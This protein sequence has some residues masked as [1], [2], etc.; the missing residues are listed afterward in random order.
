MVPTALREPLT[1]QH[2]ADLHHLAHAKV[3]TSLARHYFWPSMRADIRRWLADCTECENEKG[4]RRLA[5]GLF[6]DHATTEPRSRYSMDFQG[7][8]QAITGETE[9]LAV[10][11]AFTKT[12]F[13]LPLKDRTAPTFVPIL[14]D[15]IWFTRGAPDSIHTDAAPEL[16]SALL[17][18]VSKPRHTTA[19]GHNAQSNGEIESWWRFWKRCM[20]LQFCPCLNTFNGRLSRNAFALRTTLSPTKLSEAPDNKTVLKDTRPS[21]HHAP[22]TGDISTED[23]PDL[24]VATHLSL[25][26]SGKL[27]RPSHQLIHHLRDQL[28]VY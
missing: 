11:D 6:A 23:L 7:Q 16:L 15:A 4:K 17:A 27:S 2:H 13:V 22:I 28:H 21:R 10:M 1:R 24:L 8:C 18:A 14:L 25:T 19:C 9:A 12:V 20:K 26:S 3:H 5:H